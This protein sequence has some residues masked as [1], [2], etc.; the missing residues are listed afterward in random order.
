MTKAAGF[1]LRLT[2]HRRELLD[3][4]LADYDRFSEAVPEFAHSRR[5]PLICFVL[6]EKGDITHLASARRGVRAGTQQSRLNLWQIHQLSKPLPTARVKRQVPARTR[7]VVAK[8]FESGGLLPPK[9]LE[10]VVDAVSALAP[11]ARGLIERYG[12]VRRDLIRELSPRMR[13]ALAG[14]KEAVATAL[15]LAGLNREELPAWSPP[16]GRSPTSFLDGLPS[17][18]VREDPMIVNDLMTFPGHEFVRKTNYGAAIFQG[19]HHHLTV[20]LVNRQP[21]E[22]TL[23]TDLIYFNETFRAFVMVQYK[24]MEQDRTTK[25]AIFRLP[26][27]LLADEI[28][29]MDAAL[30]RLRALNSEPILAGFRLNENPFFLKFCPRIQFDP[31][32]SG[33]VK[34][35]YIPLDYWRL[36]ERDPALHGPRGG[37]TLSYRNVGRYLD[38]TSF[39]T[40]VAKAWVGTSVTQSSVLEE[41]IRSTLASGRAAAIGIRRADTTEDSSHDSVTD[42]GPLFE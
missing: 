40:L 12:R 7:F 37:R 38:N 3:E 29:R 28:G 14:E 27:P 4:T 8:R 1:V 24:A 10:H 15:L 6:D 30:K 42:E 34:G 33:L 35:M 22:N 16:A 2:S 32:S 23:G 5:A 39:A 11:D 13:A 21:L 17:S 19:E 9:S 31:D 26:N 41:L 20:I 36:L 25:E 18:R